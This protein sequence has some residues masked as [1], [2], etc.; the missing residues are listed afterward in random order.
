MWDFQFRDVFQANYHVTAVP[1]VHW[2]GRRR[3]L[4]DHDPVF[5]LE[6][7]ADCTAASIVTVALLNSSTAPDIHPCAFSSWARFTQTLFVNTSAALRVLGSPRDLFLVLARHSPAQHLFAWDHQR[8]RRAEY[9]EYEHAALATTEPP[10]PA[11]PFARRILSIQAITD[12]AQVTQLHLEEIFRVQDSFVFEVSSAFRAN[13]RPL[14]DEQA[15]LW[16]LAWPPRVFT[17]SPA[18]PT[19]EHLLA[20]LLASAELH[21]LYYDQLSAGALRTAPA[22]PDLAAA[23]PRLLDSS[24]HPAFQRQ[25]LPA[26]LRESFAAQPAT[27]AR[28]FIYDL[29]YS[30]VNFT[31]ASA[32]CDF[33]AVQ[34]CSAWRVS[35]FNATIAAAIVYS[36]LFSVAR[37]LN[38]SF[39]AALA[40]PLFALVVL[41][42]AYDYRWTCFPAIPTCLFQDVAA[43]QAAIFPPAITIPPSLL[44]PDCQPADGAAYDPGCLISCQAPPF[45]FT[46]WR[47][48]S[49]WLAAELGLSGP[50]LDA[51]L[52]LRLSEPA[53]L[54]AIF[55]EKRATRADASPSL[56]FANRLCA[57]LHSYTVI[58]ALAAAWLV[59]LV[60][61]TLL[62]LALAFAL[63]S[64]ETATL[65]IVYALTE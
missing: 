19:G 45:A 47:P 58:P 62:R 37:A 55:A 53:A 39:A 30:A 18:C 44:R 49:A 40:L 23:W 28:D 12:A 24:D 59:A 46:D 63:Y 61:G 3:L 16:T 65:V 52:Y 7:S 34:T 15:R 29:F 25:P 31:R 20:A 4:L 42:V 57:A 9:A 17:T 11:S 48:V 51:A 60:L 56:L 41:A 33:D 43:S 64:F 14:T 38:L 21:R 36:A 2:W 54:R 1:V 26:F 32:R 50:V 6:P 10:R 8:R 22:S 27:R 13:Y 5:D 35:L